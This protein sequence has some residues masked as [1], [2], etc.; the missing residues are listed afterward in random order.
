[1][2]YKTPLTSSNSLEYKG[3]LNRPRYMAMILY[4]ELILKVS[5]S[6]R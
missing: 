2:V 6:D 3:E 4:K 5:K 1:M